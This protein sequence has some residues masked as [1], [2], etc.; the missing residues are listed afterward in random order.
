MT[1][2]VAEINPAV[3]I[4]PPVTFAL[5]DNVVALITL[6]PVILPPVPPPLTI[7]PATDTSPPVS[8]LPPVMLPVLLTGLEPSAAKLA[9]TLALP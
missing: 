5:A 2:P 8:K 6:A 7:L 4:L 9:T 1:L 3:K